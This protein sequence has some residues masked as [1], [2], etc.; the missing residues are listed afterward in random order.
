MRP[1][2]V[3][4]QFSAGLNSWARKLGPL[5]FHFKEINM[6]N[7]PPDEMNDPFDDLFGKPNL[8]EGEDKERYERLRTA[9]IRDLK[10][11]NVFVSCCRFSGRL[12]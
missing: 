1:V 12:D 10:P 11:K 7:Q 2:L 4:Q 8:L 3:E 9:V 5:H 6:Q